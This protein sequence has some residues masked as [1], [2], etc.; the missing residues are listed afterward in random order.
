MYF[1]LKCKGPT[2]LPMDAASKDGVHGC[3]QT[4]EVSGTTAVLQINPIIDPCTPEHRGSIALQAD[5][6]RRGLLMD[7]GKLRTVKKRQHR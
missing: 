6:T 1:Q 5:G 7:N 3:V 4:R 2:V